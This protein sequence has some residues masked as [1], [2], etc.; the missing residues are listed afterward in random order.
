MLIPMQELLSRS[1]WAYNATGAYITYYSM[2]VWPFV[3][4]SQES[5]IDLATAASDIR[6]NT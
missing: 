1:G 3:I 6:N 2:C 5:L 4:L